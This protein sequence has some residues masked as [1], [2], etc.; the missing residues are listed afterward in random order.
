MTGQ[1]GKL[2][3][4]FKS[5]S[6][7]TA[8]NRLLNF[9]QK[10]TNIDLML[11]AGRRAADQKREEV[12]KLN[13]KIVITLL[14]VA[15]FLARQ[16]LAFRG[17]ANSEG[18]FVAAVNLMRRRDPVLD[19]WFKDSNLRPYHCNY[20]HH[21]SQNEFLE[22]LGSAVHKSILKDI[23][24]A[25]FI[26]I[27]TDSTMDASHKEIYTI[28]VRFVKNFNVQERIVSAAELNSKE[29]FNFFTGSI[30]RFFLFCEQLSSSSYGLLLKDLSK[31]RW[32]NRYEAVRAVIVSYKEII[33]TLQ[34]LSEDNVEKNTQQ[35]AKNLRN[36]N[37]MASINALIVHLQK[38]QM[39]I[40]ATMDIIEDTVRL[41]HQMY[42][43]DKTL[44]AII[45]ISKKDLEK[46][47][48]NID[49]DYEFQRLQRRNKNLKS[50]YDHYRVIFQK[51]I[52]NMNEEFKYY[53]SLLTTNL[54]C[55]AHL[56]TKRIN[57]FSKE[58]AEKT[59]SIVPG[60]HNYEL[61]FYEIHLL[62][63]KIFESD[64]IANVF[65]TTQVIDAYPRTKKVYQY[66]LTIPVSIASNERSF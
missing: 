8:E 49:L 61:C 6:H 35:T 5:T 9:S 55:F 1:D 29:L 23:N 10:K 30:K 14:D 63:S 40:L 2:V 15:R 65:N 28:I 50:I 37:L 20:L 66:L 64:S 56:S 32:S 42:D 47:N 44:D 16:S 45:E 22:L 60:I 41:L 58:D 54:K 4:H 27:T 51:L 13:E 11:N 12:L 59:H 26:S 53:L 52:M 19:Q 3:K 25:P 24:D 21:D 34:K 38:I 7:M 39:D 18:N 46:H 31:T 43:D 57:T 33:N 48:V 62:K 36:K 17:N